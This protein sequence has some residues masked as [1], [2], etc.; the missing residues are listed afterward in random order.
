MSNVNV[1]SNL[2]GLIFNE[3]VTKDL[4]R[5]CSKPLLNSTKKEGNW[6]SSGGEDFDCTYKAQEPKPL[7]ISCFKM[8]ERSGRVKLV[9]TSNARNTLP[10]ETPILL[11]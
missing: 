11:L 1:L 5:Q 9:D 3:V 7:T 10:S 8:S 6:F 4:K 2:G